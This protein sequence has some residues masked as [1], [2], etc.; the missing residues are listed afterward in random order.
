CGSRISLSTQIKIELA[1]SLFADMRVDYIALEEVPAQDV[2]PLDGRDVASSAVPEISPTLGISEDLEFRIIN[3]GTSTVTDVPTGAIVKMPD[4]TSTTY[5]STNLGISIQPS[6]TVFRP[7]TSLADFSQVGNYEI[8]F[9]TSLEEDVSVFNDTLEVI[10]TGKADVYTEGL[11]FVEDLD[12]N[13]PRTRFFTSRV[14]DFYQAAYAV[15]DRGNLQPSSDFSPGFQDIALTNGGNPVS[16]LF[17][18]DLSDISVSEDELTLEAEIANRSSNVAQSYVS[19]RG[20]IDQPWINVYSITDSIPS[21][22]FAPPTAIEIIDITE[23]L[24]AAGQTYGSTFQMRVINN[25][26]GSST[27]G[28]SIIDLH[29]ISLKKTG[30]FDIANAI[31][32]TVVNEGYTSYKRYLGN[33]FEGDITGSITYTASSSNENVALVTIEGDSLVMT[34][35]TA[36]GMTEIRID[37]TDEAE[38]E[39]SLRFELTSENL[40]PVVS[41]TIEN[42]ML[43]RNFGTLSIELANV[44]Q[45]AGNDPLSFSI[46]SSDES[47]LTAIIQEQNIVLQ[48]QGLGSATIS[49]TAT[50]DENASIN[51]DFTVSVSNSAVV[52]SSVLEDLM[53][54][55]GFVTTSI[56][57]TAFFQDADGDVI[58]FEVSSANEQVVS[59]TLDG[60]S[61][62]VLSEKGN[63]TASIT[64]SAQDD[65]EEGTSSTFTVTVIDP[66]GNSENLDVF[67]FYPNP[68][69]S[70]IFLNHKLA[71]MSLRLQD[72]SGKELPIIRKGDVL[73]LSDLPASTYILSVGDDEG[74]ELSKH[75][76]IKQ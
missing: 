37:A 67:I 5:S 12:A 42:Q 41:N 10:Q 3:N 6:D 66:L 26:T 1:A 52:S 60:P 56:N 64:V 49:L 47:I 33:V 61:T 29:S 57:L 53:L 71:S 36:N 68:T 9:F 76:I 59:A 45:D 38:N 16:I 62:L 63:G 2:R 75:K 58:D 32:D 7:V 46:S 48:E 73:D 54:E 22:F 23:R 19:I 50:D 39:G 21:D 69:R 8:T 74:N 51:L 13:I 25:S 27:T 17:T 20:D 14:F 43:L 24:V 28:A 40:A 72:I 35:G 4:G 65:L 31:P 34:E 44:F 18:L 30:S 55:S 11:P 70:V 15:I